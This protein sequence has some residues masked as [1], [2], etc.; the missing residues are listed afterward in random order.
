MANS[1]FRFWK[2]PYKI[3]QSKDLDYILVTEASFGLKL[4]I[5]A[6]IQSK[7]KEQEF[8]RN[9]SMYLIIINDWNDD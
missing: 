7:E 1:L 9:Y 3:L 8:Y 6:V 5:Y 4:C 2:S